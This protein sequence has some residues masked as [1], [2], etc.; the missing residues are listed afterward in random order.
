M[1][2]TLPETFLTRP[3][4]HRGLHDI[5]DGR[6]ENSRAAF[7]AAIVHGYGIELDVQLTRDDKAIVFHDYHLSRLTTA[8]GPIRQ[9]TALEMI[10]IALIGGGD[11]AE[12]LGDILEFIGGRVPVLI[13]LKDQD[14]EMGPDIGPLET[15]VAQAISDYTGD[16]AV[17]SFN[18]H[19]TVMM[20]DCLPKVPRGIVTSAYAEN[21]HLPKT[22]RDN[23]RDIPDFERAQ[24]SFISHEVKDLDRKRVAD[25]KAGGENILCWTVTSQDMADEALKMAQNITF[26]R[27]LPA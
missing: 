2:V 14:G 6:P 20:A 7:E 13:E 26:E 24:A 21:W 5:N 9:R 10:D 16:V 25:L 8:S 1:K 19:S 12:P 23:L 3:I 22:V 4:A 27:Y 11:H 17:M 15:C 18:P